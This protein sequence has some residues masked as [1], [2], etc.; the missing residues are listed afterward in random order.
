MQHPAIEPTHCLCNTLNA[1]K[2]NEP[3]ALI[4]TTINSDYIAPTS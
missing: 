3:A 1:R 4:H 2:T